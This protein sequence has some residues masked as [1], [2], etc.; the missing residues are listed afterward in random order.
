MFIVSES[1]AGVRELQPGNLGHRAET[2]AASDFLT[3]C[4]EAAIAF[5]SVGQRSHTWASFAGLW[6]AGRCAWETDTAWCPC[7][8]LELSSDSG[9]PAR[10]WKFQVSLQGTSWTLLEVEFHL[11]CTSAAGRGPRAVSAGKGEAA[12][13]ARLG[14]R[15]LMNEAT[16]SQQPRRSCG[17][18]YL[19]CPW[20]I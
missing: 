7:A 9:K 15:A 3:R 4:S 18:R 11:S 19:S 20:L 1:L 16:S 6:V 10:T 12:T 14:Q 8:L 17:K 13:A 2:G 5:P